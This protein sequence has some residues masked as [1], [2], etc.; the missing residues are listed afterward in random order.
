MSFKFKLADV[1]ERLVPNGEG[2]YRV[3]GL[4]LA[5]EINIRSLVTH[6]TEVVQDKDFAK[7]DKEISDIEY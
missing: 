4:R 7:V 6:R 2:P 5:G 3:V 1:V